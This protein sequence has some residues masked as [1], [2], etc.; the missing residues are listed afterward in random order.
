MQKKSRSNFE[1]ICK[2]V[3]F[4]YH[5]SQ[6][7]MGLKA[8]LFSFFLLFYGAFFSVTVAQED[9]GM[10]PFRI[11]F[12]SDNTDTILYQQSHALII[13]VSE[14][15]NGLPQ[16][17]GVLKD[18]EAVKTVLEKVGFSVDT[19]KN[20]TKV[21][22]EEGC[23]KFISKWGNNYE[24]R[25]LFYYAGHGDKKEMEYGDKKGYL[26]LS[27][28]PDP[29]ED[30][31][32]LSGAISMV[33]VKEWATNINA[34][35]ALFVLDVCYSGEI[36]TQYRSSG[37]PEDISFKCSEPVRQFITAGDDDEQVPDKSTFREQFVEGLNGEA[38][39]DK[40]GF[41]TGIELGEFLAKEV[42]IITKGAQHPQHGKIDVSSLRKGDFV[43]KSPQNIY[44]KITPSIRD[45]RDVTQYG[46]LDL[47]TY[48]SGYLYINGIPRVQ[49]NAGQPRLIFLEEGINT[50]T[51][52]GKDTIT[53][54]VTI[55]P[56]RR[57]EFTIGSPKPADYL[58]EEKREETSSMF[59]VMVKVKG[60]SFQMGNNRG[61]SAE[62]PVHTVLVNDFSISKYEITQKQWREIM[63]RNPKSLKFKG[64]DQ[65]P[66]ENVTWKEI[67]VFLKR[68]SA[69]MGQ[70]YRLPTEAE[71]EYAARGGD[72]DQD[73]SSFSSSNILEEVA[74]YSENSSFK[75]HPVGQKK[76]NELGLYDMIGNVAE[77]CNDRFST[78]YYQHSPADNPVGPHSGEYRVVRGGSWCDLPHFTMTTSRKGGLPNKRDYSCG[79]RVCRSK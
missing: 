9:R 28:S 48:I 44:P 7:Q 19:L 14:Y 45:E 78:D 16:L 67:Q 60:G 42:S 72:E 68:L 27:D 58:I 25:L 34:K 49:V 70:T 43:F 46:Q 20:P 30:S 40:D 18:I 47:T 1:Y 50:I 52:H 56:D 63:G 13:G 76:P 38:D 8:Y 32:F 74:W 31:S 75:T 79:F 69:R 15:T 59:P 29:H 22:M 62:R 33:R 71:W 24:N 17:P 4:A 77:W 55:V 26:L 23:S 66:V 37:I 2:S 54:T 73:Y 12:P 41:I 6:D 5:A 36:F 21:E 64:C 11:T 10:K 57:E 39:T 61:S 53:E 35:H 65:C 3:I 51:I